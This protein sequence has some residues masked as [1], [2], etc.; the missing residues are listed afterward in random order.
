MA[1]LS[2]PPG[3]TGSDPPRRGSLYGQWNAVPGRLDSGVPAGM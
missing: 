3:P 1:N 2:Y